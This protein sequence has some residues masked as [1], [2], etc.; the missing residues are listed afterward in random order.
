MK[1]EAK[2]PELIYS[3]ANALLLSGGS[4]TYELDR[5]QNMYTALMSGKDLRYKS[6][7][8]KEKQQEIATRYGYA[9]YTDMLKVLLNTDGEGH[10][11]R[12]ELINKLLDGLNDSLKK[13][14]INIRFPADNRVI[15]SMIESGRSLNLFHDRKG[16]GSHSKESRN[17]WEASLLSKEKSGYD[18]KAPRAMSQY[19]A[20]VRPTYGSHDVDGRGHCMKH[21]VANQY[22]EISL[23]LNTSVN[24]RATFTMT[25]SS[26]MLN[27]FAP[28]SFAKL[29]PEHR[30][31]LAHNYLRK[32]TAEESDYTEAQVWGGI[33]YAKDVKHV[34]VEKLNPTNPVNTKLLAF[35][36]KFKLPI[37][38]PDGKV[39][40]EP[41]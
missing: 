23:S 30:A 11:A 34:I 24:Q 2:I 31:Q 16:K 27:N 13:H 17:K 8:N 5:L 4:S 41:K 26:S 7:V 19:G 12:Q 3:R 40:Y 35:C 33:D 25:N 20:D 37:A 18:K 9:K 29:K 39:L 36:D 6:S 28:D 10:A 22:G 32:A 38:N 1:G 21:D 14:P 15:S